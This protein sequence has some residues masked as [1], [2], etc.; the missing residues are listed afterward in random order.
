MSRHCHISSLN[1]DDSTE[2]TSHLLTERDEEVPFTMPMI[3]HGI[4]VSYQTEQLT[5]QIARAKEEVREF[6]NLARRGRVNKKLKRRERRAGPD[7][8]S[9]HSLISLVSQSFPF[10]PVHYCQTPRTHAESDEFTSG[11][12]RTLWPSSNPSTASP[13]MS[14]VVDE[15]SQT[16]HPDSSV[17]S[18]PATVAE[19]PECPPVDRVWRR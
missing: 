14:V 10:P 16:A 5:Q 4:D 15:S 19:R 1:A 9:W 6:L 8:R 7:L 2:P 13:T 18:G 12:T 3:L 11:V 17:A